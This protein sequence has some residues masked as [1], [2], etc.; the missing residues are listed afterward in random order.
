MFEVSRL[1]EYTGDDEALIARVCSNFM[2]TSE[3]YVSAMAK[4]IR[5]VDPESLARAAHSFKPVF[6]LFGDGI[7]KSMCVSLEQIGRNGE[8]A[9]AE[10]VFVPFRGRVAQ[11]AIEV[12]RR[13]K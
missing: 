1:K 10:G 4:A 11:I 3:I 2:Q 8:M 6:D 7:A 13:I 12:R 9:L 5:D